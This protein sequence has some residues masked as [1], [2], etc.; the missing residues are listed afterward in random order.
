MVDSEGANEYDSELVV[1][2]RRGGI[3]DTRELLTG[4]GIDPRNSQAV[5]LVSNQLE[6]LRRFGLVIETHNGWKWVG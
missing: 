5:R 2:L 3:I 1:I 4:L 6:G